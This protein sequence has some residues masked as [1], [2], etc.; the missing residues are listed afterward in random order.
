MSALII[1]DLNHSQA[2]DRKAVA[3]ITGGFARA[4]K[5]AQGTHFKEAVVTCFST[6]FITDAADAMIKAIGE[7]LSSQARKA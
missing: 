2:L 3:A 6:S 4:K 5:C 7:A 1:A